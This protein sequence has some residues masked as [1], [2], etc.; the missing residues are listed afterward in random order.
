M[1]GC[2]QRQSRNEPRL[3][4]R[5]KA[6]FGRKVGAERPIDKDVTPSYLSPA[7]P[8]HNISR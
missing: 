8:E 5:L 4:T 3:A 1:G 6:D 2:R 7:R